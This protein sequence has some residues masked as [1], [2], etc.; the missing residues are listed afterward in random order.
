MKVGDL[1]SVIE[2]RGCGQFKKAT[3]L[4]LAV[5]VE[6]NETDD[7]YFENVGHVNLG[8]DITVVLNT[9]KLSIFNQQSLEV[10]NESR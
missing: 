2:E 1:V 3:H 9:G 7:L 6:I 8:D 10:V 5:V 4:G